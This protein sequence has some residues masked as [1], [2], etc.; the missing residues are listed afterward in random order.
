MSGFDFGALRDP[1]APTPD[2]HHRDAVE[3]RAHKLRT[4]ERRNRTLLSGLAVI[5]VVAAVAGIVATRPDKDQVTVTT[6]PTSTTAPAPPS[7][8]GDR[9]VP[10]TT[11]ENGK[12]TLPVALPDGETFTMQYPE[13]MKVAQLGFAGQVGVGWNG[14]PRCCGRSVRI[15]YTTI[16]RVYGDAKPIAVYR[17]AHGENV[18]F[19]R[20]PQGPGPVDTQEDLAFQFGP[21]LVT[22]GN[23][24]T[25]GPDLTDQERATWARSLTGT[26]VGGY[27]FLTARAPIT[28]GN[29]F[30]GAFGFRGGANS[31]G[32]TA[33]AYCT[34]PESKSSVRKRTTNEGGSITVSWCVGRNLRVNVVGSPAFVKLSDKLVV[35]DFVNPGGGLVP[36]S[37]TTTTTT[38]AV[39]PANAVSASFVSADHGWL[40]ESNGDVVETTD[41][42]ATWHASGSLGRSGSSMKI[43]FADATHG[44]AFQ[45]QDT[46]QP[47]T[48]ATDDGGATW[49]TLST[50][51]SGR[52]YDLAIS[53]GTVYAVTFDNGNFRIWSSPADSLSWTE[54]PITIPVGGGP[55][56]SIQLV[57]SNG[58]GWLVEVDRLVVGGAQMSTSGHWSTWTPPCSTVN[59]PASLAAWS[60]TDLIASCDEGVWGS[61]PAPAKAVYTSHDAGATF[62]RH[63]APVFGAVTAA[64]PN[65]ALLATGD[66]IR[67]SVDG[68]QTWT[69]VVGSAMSNPGGS[70]PLDLGFTSNTQGF[71]IFANGQM[72]MTYDSGA[73]WSAVTQP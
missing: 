20:A 13:A 3:A 2:S 36:T 50:P 69:T 24:S 34:A 15:T 68:G 49:T 30:I 16:A 25:S 38:P 21:W 9:F 62:Q 61:P 27:L 31:V 11:T 65:D 48:L 19:F 7:P 17:G 55:D 57:F 54:D 44:F 71:V 18:R 29:K 22:V 47:A 26:E 51:W 66:T 28:L 52:V 12:T 1:D 67:R 60:A 58:A 46:N 23:S 70:Q 56:P 35:G 53:H 6:D 43:R 8:V 42:G 72:V 63:D 59:G 73:T 33:H 14:K 45:T 40:V 5:V 41:A 39:A 32:L 64:D 10:P 4:K 37:T